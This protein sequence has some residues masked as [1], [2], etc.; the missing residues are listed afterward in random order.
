[1]VPFQR[2]D[3]KRTI[4]EG[5]KEKKSGAKVLVKPFQTQPFEEKRTDHPS[6]TS[7]FFLNTKQKEKPTLT[8][9]N[10]K[11]VSYLS[12]DTK[13]A[14]FSHINH[15]LQ[16]SVALLRLYVVFTDVCIKHEKYSC[17]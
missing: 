12:N 8:W 15:R 16:G 11:N 4:E 6:W 10:E 7:A 9:H 14:G 3:K 1:V 13:H 2:K 5:E 17:Y